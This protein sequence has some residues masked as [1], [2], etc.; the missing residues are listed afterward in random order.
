V[1]KGFISKF[2]F[3]CF[4]FLYLCFLRLIDFSVL[5]CTHR[6]FNARSKNHLRII[7]ELILVEENKVLW[8]KTLKK[9]IRILIFTMREDSDSQT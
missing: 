6:E 9:L 2:Y 5:R 7:K 4:T 3:I 8:R 1:E